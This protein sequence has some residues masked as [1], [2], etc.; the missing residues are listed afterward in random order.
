MVEKDKI[1]TYYDQ[2]VTEQE[3]RGVNTRH[4]HIIDK[5]VKAGLKSHHHVLEVGC[6]I[7]TVS[8]L[9]AKKTKKGS[10]LAVDI[11]PE[12][13]GKAKLLWGNHNNLSFKVSDMR[14]FNGEGQKFD[15]IVFPDV[16]EHIPVDQHFELFK[17]VKKHSTK[18]AVIFINIPAP[19]FLEWMIEHEPQKLQVIDQ[20]LNTADLIGNVSRNGFYLHKMET[21]NIFYN[22]NDYQYFVFKSQQP[23]HK[24]TM[25]SKLTVLTERI[26]I[27]IRNRLK[28]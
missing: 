19:R 16:L 10:V 20:P 4:L 28:D 12:S 23:I 22:E 7:G 25:R 26:K 11:S 9:I 27:R 14:D 18:D 5:L 6:G 24:T 21:Y 17:T 13:I 3:K 15:F 8:Q 1:V 2:F